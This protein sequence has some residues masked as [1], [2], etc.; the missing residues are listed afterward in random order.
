MTDA[1]PAATISTAAPPL[2]YVAPL[3]PPLSESADHYETHRRLSID[4][5]GPP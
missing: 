5:D 4:G 2:L 3:K 1:G